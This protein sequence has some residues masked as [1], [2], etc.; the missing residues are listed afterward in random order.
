MSLAE[1]LDISILQTLQDKFCAQH[2]VAL[3]LFGP[4]GET[5]TTPHSHIGRSNELKEVL[6]FFF[7]IDENQVRVTRHKTTFSSYL[8]GMVLRVMCPLRTGNS[9][10]GLVCLVQVRRREDQ[11]DLRTRLAQI[12]SESDFLASL[13][14]QLQ[15]PPETHLTLIENFKGIIEALLN[16]ALAP[17]DATRLRR[18]DQHGWLFT[19]AEGGVFDAEGEAVNLLGYSRSADISGHNLIDT[20]FATPETRKR[21]REALAAGRSAQWS[22]LLLVRQDGSPLRADVT[23][24]RCA[25]DG[26]ETFGYECQITPVQ[27]WQSEPVRRPMPELPAVVSSTR[28]VSQLLD[29]LPYPLAVLDERGRICVW[30]RDIEELFGISALSV[31]E[32]E[33]NQLILD[34]DQI[35]WEEGIRRL[36]SS[37]EETNVLFNREIT[38]LDKE[39]EFIRALPALSK[40]RILGRDFTSVTLSKWEKQQRAARGGEG[41]PGLA[42]EKQAFLDRLKGIMAEC[43]RRFDRIAEMASDHDA[44]RQAAELGRKL[45]YFSGIRTPKLKPVILNELISHAVNVKTAAGLSIQLDLDENLETVLVDPIQLEEALEILCNRASR[46]DSRI[47]TLVI[48]TRTAYRGWLDL[49]SERE[50]R[51]KMSFLLQVSDD[52]AGLPPQLVDHLFE[53]FLP[54]AESTQSLDLAALYGIVLANGGRIDVENE[55]GEGTTFSLLF[56]ILET[57]AEMPVDKTEGGVKT[58]LIID[59]DKGIIEVNSL[60]LKHFGYTTLAATS[61]EKGLELM[62]EHAHEIDLVILDV[63]LPDMS[64]SECAVRLLDLSPNTPIILSSGHHYEA[65][66]KV[67][68]S[69][70][71]VWLQKPYSFGVLMQTIEEILTKSKN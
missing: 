29:S 42:P 5:V 54:E 52:G 70:G 11:K 8:N 46:P 47:S 24:S 45:G 67:M 30:N 7:H 69:T 48:R 23:L 19:T 50:N 21:G 14:A 37:S 33:F 34:E 63:T 66:S 44:G 59:D 60:A 25:G 17:G 58:I 53:P 18:S 22:S 40:S 6:P 36:R 2:G 43:A 15:Q 26:G 65:F 56:P 55:S 32:T 64:G 62:R 39:G 3:G 71:A 20:F 68:Q 49:D 13:D 57:E 27:G 4:H 28:G 12:R 51:S 35:Q 38:F 16:A 61:A 31:L 9:T 41:A 10:H 1:I